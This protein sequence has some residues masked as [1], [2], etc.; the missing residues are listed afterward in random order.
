MLYRFRFVIG[1]ALVVI[2][3]ALASY[4]VVSAAMPDALLPAGST[5]YGAVGVA[6]TSATGTNSASFTNL[7]GLSTTITIP[8]GK[9]GDV[10]VFF[11]GT[12]DASTNNY[13]Y[14]RAKVGSSV[15]R[16]DEVV[17]WEFNSTQQNSC[18]NF[19]KTGV[20]AGTHT[21][22]MQWKSDNGTIIGAWARSMIVIVNVR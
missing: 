6:A 5:R 8:A 15:A 16:P 11:C 14:V 13:A 12:I 22:K 9:K 17:A 4:L 18:V 21:V 20:D 10:M 7:P 3:S 1:G 2:L 19:F